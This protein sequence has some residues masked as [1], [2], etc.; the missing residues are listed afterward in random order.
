MSSYE[1]KVLTS[2]L[3]FIVTNL[4]FK[5]MLNINLKTIL[6]VFIYNKI[7]LNINNILVYKIVI[8]L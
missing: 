5:V 1:I 8:F 3:V 7:I 6:Y 4:K 2:K